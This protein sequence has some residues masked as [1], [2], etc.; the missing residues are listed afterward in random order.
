M[1]QYLLSIC[2]VVLIGTIFNLILPHG[3]T[4]KSISS[5]FGVLLLLVIV[6]PIIT[7]KNSNNDF[8]F[9]IISGDD[10]VIYDE[11]LDYILYS[12]VDLYKKNVNKIL[13]KNGIENAVI[14]IYY[15]Q[16]DDV[17]FSVD[18]IEIDLSKSV[19]I[20]EESHINIIDDV[21]TEINNK[22]G[23]SKEQVRIIE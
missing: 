22:L 17:S 20:S 15:H 19:I 13:Q 23:I 14:E 18:K 2:G 1:K 9:S 6:K 4:S 11:Y 8:N 12:K 7:I 3:K 21:L 5:I 10:V 16:I